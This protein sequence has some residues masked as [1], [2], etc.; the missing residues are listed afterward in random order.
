MEVCDRAFVID[1][2]RFVHEAP[3]EHLDAI[4]I[5][6]LL[7]VE[8][9][10]IKLNPNLKGLNNHVP[11]PDPKLISR[12]AEEQPSLHNRWHPDIPMLAWVKP[13]D[14]FRVECVDWTGDK[15]LTTIT[16]PMC[17]M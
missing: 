3:R 5:R 8:P 16:P 1:R 7:S 2:G 6:A 12:P 17:A 9:G 15:F 11:D 13:G 4:Q 14:E 10:P